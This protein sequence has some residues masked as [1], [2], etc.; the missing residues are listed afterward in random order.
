MAGLVPAIHDFLAPPRQAVDARAKPEHD[1]VNW[2]I[3]IIASVLFH[4]LV[5]R[6]GAAFDGGGDQLV[7][8][9]FTLHK[10]QHA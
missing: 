8:A 2:A 3:A 5:A 7:Q 4:L 1:V 10:F 6:A 9:Q